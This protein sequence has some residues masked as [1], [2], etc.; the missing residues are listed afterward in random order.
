MPPWAVWALEL[1]DCGPNMLRSM[2]Q[3]NRILIDLFD[4]PGPM[5]QRVGIAHDASDAYSA[6]QR[7]N[8]PSRSVLATSLRHSMHSD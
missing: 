2:V 4:G 5:G 6:T 1:K 7:L 3:N 8:I